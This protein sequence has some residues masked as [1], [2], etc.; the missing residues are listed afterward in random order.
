MFRHQRSIQP[1]LVSVLTV[2]VFVVGT[3]T[4]LAVKPNPTPPGNHLNIT[5]VEVKFDTSMIVITGEHFSF[6]NTLDVTLG[7]FGTL[8]IVGVPTDTDIVVD[9]PAGGLPAGD[10]LLTVSTGTGQSKNDE[11]DLTVVQEVV[12]PTCPCEGLS[13]GGLTWDNTF[14]V[15]SCHFETV[16][17]VLIGTGDGISLGTS[18]VR[19]DGDPTCDIRNGSDVTTVPLVNYD[20]A[21]ACRQSLLAIGFEAGGC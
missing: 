19:H 21:F 14:P 12:T 11:Y 18:D 8:N 15:D 20:E 1:L 5:E 17:V 7:G 4:T 16:A 2:A 3:T 9:F 6:G 10:Y 13:A